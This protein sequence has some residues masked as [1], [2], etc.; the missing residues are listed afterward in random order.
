MSFLLVELDLDKCKNIWH[1]STGLLRLLF[2]FPYSFILFFILDNFS[3]PIFKFTD[4][5][6]I[7]T[8][9]LRSLRKLFFTYAFLFL[10]YL[11][12]EYSSKEYCTSRIESL[13]L[14][15]SF[16]FLTEISYPFTHYVYIFLRI[17]EHY[18]DDCFR[19]YSVF[20]FVFCFFL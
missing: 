15:Y 18:Y 2:L 3:L 17:F 7:F 20:L 19:L 5:S 1:W 9:L 10:E 16:F 12:I 4:S 14:F 13:V 8:M 6:D 11:E